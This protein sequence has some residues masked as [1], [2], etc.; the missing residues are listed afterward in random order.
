M[1]DLTGKR[2]LITGGCGFIG[3]HLVQYL[4]D[5]DNTIT[6]LD[7]LSTGT[8]EGIPIGPH[9]K[10]VIGSILDKALVREVC[11]DQ[12]LIIHLAS[13][14]G[15]ELVV[16]EPMQ[17]YHVSKYGTRNILEISEMD[18]PVVLFS[19]SAVYGLT[20]DQQSQEAQAISQDAARDYDAGKLGYASGK[21]ALEQEGLAA[22]A[23]GKQVQIVRPFNVIGHG[24]SSTYGMVV[25]KFVKLAMEG[26]DLTVYGDGSQ[27]R[28]FTYVETFCEVLEQLIINPTAW[29]R[30][31]NVINVGSDQ[32][33]SIN[34]L[35]NI[36]LGHSDT[37][38]KI[39]Y[40]RY[41]SVFPG[42]KDVLHRRPDT[43][44]MKALIG[45]RDW[46]TIEEIVHQ[47]FAKHTQVGI[48]QG[49]SLQRA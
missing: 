24:Q 38:S 34:A 35:A 27:T 12:D 10:V 25:P 2:I 43:S 40:K 8:L 33:T 14:V 37:Q 20:A 5:R 41:D 16:E 28:S 22:M 7:D 32:M 39:E 30:G 46:L 47:I 4:A 29:K 3:T 11:A 1:N 44:K 45:D 26:K 21:W 17:S 15:M 19:S 23:V 31:N 42:K 18:T 13:L 49:W 6:I 9:V 48:Q 36:I